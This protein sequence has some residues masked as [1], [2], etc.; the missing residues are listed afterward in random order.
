MHIVL[1]SGMCCF[2]R[3][4]PLPHLDI[5]GVNIT[6]VRV[7]V[8]ECKLTTK[9]HL[10]SALCRELDGEWTRDALCSAHR[11]ERVSF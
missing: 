4:T 6:Y 2:I 7:G 10:D 1:D 8:C 9:H 11:T 3:P 5:D